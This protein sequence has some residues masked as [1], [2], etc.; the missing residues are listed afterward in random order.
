M[1][2]IQLGVALTHFIYEYRE[3]SLSVKSARVCSFLA[4]AA[5]VFFVRFGFSLFEFSAPV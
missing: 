3:H 1:N 4:A 2:Q 5:V